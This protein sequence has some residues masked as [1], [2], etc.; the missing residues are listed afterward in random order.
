MPSSTPAIPTN[1]P[2][3][4]VKSAFDKIQAESYDDVSA[5]EL[6]VVDV[7]GGKGIG[8]I[9]NGDYVVYKS[10]D[11]GSG[12]SS[13]KALVASSLSSSIE[14]RLNGPS[15]T[16]LGK[17]SVSS[18][19]GWDTYEEITCTI[20]NVTGKNDLYL[21]FSGAVNV[22]WFTFTGGGTIS[23]N[24]GDLDGDGS[25][26]ALDLALLRQHLLGKSEL[27]GESLANADVNGDGSV[28]SL[29]FAFVRQYLVGKI[30]TF[31]AQK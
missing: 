14:L 17:L 13:F 31:P 26:N 15:G 10:V 11:F 22:D 19:G 7:P 8:Y 4:T 25:V 30:S 6:S 2:V 9:N 29:D 1:T 21:V 28:D 3:P 27:K 16:L 12:A 23:K 5:R 20:S 18:T 24:Y